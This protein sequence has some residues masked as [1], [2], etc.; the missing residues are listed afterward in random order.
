MESEALCSQILPVVLTLVGSEKDASE[1]TGRLVL[2]S[3]SFTQSHFHKPL[4]HLL[5]LLQCNNLSCLLAKQQSCNLKT[6]KSA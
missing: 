5:P 2:P 3:G 4:P 6:S 1:A